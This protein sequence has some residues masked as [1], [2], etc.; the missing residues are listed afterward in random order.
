M[1]AISVLEE[2]GAGE[3]PTVIVEV[4]HSDGKKEHIVA[5]SEDDH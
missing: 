5:K 3:E 4:D 1:A 2:L